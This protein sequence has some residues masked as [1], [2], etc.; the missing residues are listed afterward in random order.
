[1][2]LRTAGHMFCRCSWWRGDTV[3]RPYISSFPLIGVESAFT[4]CIVFLFISADAASVQ[5]EAHS[6]PYKERILCPF[7]LT[8]KGSTLEIWGFASAAR[9]GSKGMG[10]TRIYEFPQSQGQ[11]FVKHRRKLDN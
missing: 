9:E 6:D 4:A 10:R 5:P 7:F 11:A 2:G 3:P 8:M 1:M